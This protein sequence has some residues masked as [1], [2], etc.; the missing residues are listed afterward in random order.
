[1]KFHNGIHAIQFPDQRVEICAG[2]ETLLCFPH[3]G[4]KLWRILKFLELG[5]SRSDLRQRAQRLDL[6]WKQVEEL[7]QHLK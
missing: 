7:L 4:E 5:S 3:L 2:M 1:M 6:E